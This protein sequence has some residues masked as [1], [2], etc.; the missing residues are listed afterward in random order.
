MVPDR[1]FMKTCIA[2][3]SIIL[4][5][6]AAPTH[7][8]WTRL[9]GPNGNGLAEVAKVPTTWSDKENIAWKAELPGPGAS[10]PII[11][12]ERIFVTCYSGYGDGKGNDM[13][14]LLRH[15][16]CVNKADGKL[17][18]DKT[19]PA[20]QPEDSYDGMLTEH[21]YASSTPVSD[22]KSVYVFFGK[23][24][25]FAFDLEGKQLW[26]TSL[27][28]GSNDR[29]WG[30]GASPV[31][32]DGKLIVSAFDEGSALFALDPAT[33]KEVWKQEVKGLGLAFNT[34]T[35]YDHDGTQDLL[36]AVPNELWSINP[37]TGKLRW[38]LT[39]DLPGNISPCVQLGDGLAYLTGG[40][41][42][43]GSLAFKPGGK[44]DITAS[45]IAWTSNDS[46]YVPSPIFHEGHLYVVNDNGFALCLE[47]KTGKQIYRERVMQSGGGGGGGGG[48]GA[49]G[50]RGGGKPFYGSP[51]LV[52]G[53]IYAPSRA[54]GTFVIA[55]K[56]TFELLATNVIASDATQF[57]ASPAVEGKRLYLRS[58]KALYSIGE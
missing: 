30:S 45:A 14:A 56:P 39:H 24:G 4:A 25:A 20:V 34:P 48:S 41:P 15:L 16:V 3:A 57:N 26:Q 12:G 47:A 37:A 32:C 2:L 40:F 7:A 36:L 51:V 28:T 11:I 6:T 54:N 29:R 23:S 19:V 49:G 53:K 10:S 50:R 21:G 43:Q 1:H 46:S 17:V 5:L 42:K 18:W 58:N 55:A 31:L 8:D 13:K 38:F 27:G 52:D 44:G 9:R 33:G 35:I 22:G